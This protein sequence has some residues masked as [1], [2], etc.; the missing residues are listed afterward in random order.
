VL[1]RTLTAL[2]LVVSFANAPRAADWPMWRGDANRCAASP[3][4]LP[5]ELH[6]QW[7]RT[8][9][10]PQPAFP[11]DPRLCADASYEPVVLGKTLF[12]P[13]MVT[14]S[15]TAFDTETGAVKWRF[16]ADGPVRF[17]P[18]AWQDRI[19]FASDDGVLYCLDAAMG[20]VLWTFN[21]LPADRQAY[22]LLGNGRLVSRWPA[23]GG[24]VLADGVV[25]FGRG[26]WPNEGVFVYAVDAGTG[27][28]IWVNRDIGW[29]KDGLIDHGLRRHAGLSPLGYMV[30]MGEKLVVPSG[31]AFPAVLDRQTGKM[32]PYSTGWGGRDGLAKGDWRQSG[33]G[34]LLFQGGD[35]HALGEKAM[36][37]AGPFEPKEHYRFAEFAEFAGTTVDQVEAWVKTECLEEV[38]RDGAR[39][40]RVRNRPSITY[41]TW[42]MRNPTPGE[43]YS[44]RSC[45]RLQVDPGNRQ[46]QGISREAVLTAAAMYYSAP[47]RNIR[48]RG[49]LHP[50]DLGWDGIEAY[51]LTKAEWGVAPRSGWGTPR[52]FVLWPHLRFKRLWRLESDLKVH[53]KAGPRLY[54]GGPGAVAAVR[55]PTGAAQPAIAWRA[56]IEGTPHRMLAADDK[57]FVVTVE[58]GL[59]CFGGREAAPVTHALPSA[60]SSGGE[61]GDTAAR[62]LD[63]S[64]VR[65]GYC[66]A[67][68]I[69]T[70]RLVT[71]L[72]VRSQLHIIVVE[73]DAAKVAESRRSLA[74]KGLYGA[75][76]H[77]LPGDLRGLK[78][79]PYWA[80]LA[81]AEAPDALADPGT[82]AAAFA[83]LRPYGGV[84][85]LALTDEQHAAFAAAVDQGGLANAGVQRQGG[86]T[87]L[88]RVGAVPGADEWTHEAGAPGNTFSSN[89]VNV[90][91]PFGV[92]W[93]GGTVDAIFPSYDY[94][95][96]RGPFALI[97]R[98]RMFALAENVLHAADIYTGR[99]LWQVELPKT[100]KTKYRRRGHMVTQRE[101]ADNFI[102]TDDALYVISKRD[103]LL[104]DPATGAEKGRIRIPEE[105][106][107]HGGWSAVRI[108]REHLFASIGGH[109]CC[110]DRHSGA[111]VWKVKSSRGQFRFAVGPDRVFCADYQPR[112]GRRR[113]ENAE[114]DL[115]TTIRALAAATGRTLWDA[116][117]TV[118]EDTPK[119]KTQKRLPPLDPRLTY[120]ADSDV[121]VLTATRSILAGYRGKT[122]ERLWS[123]PIP[124][125]DPPNNFSGPEPPIALSDKLITHSGYVIDLST[126]EKLTRLWRGT[127][128]GTR[129]CNRVVAN[130]FII[131]L[132]DAH[133]SYFEVLTGRQT[134][135]RAVRSGCTNSQLA[136]GGILNAP[137]F[138]HGCACNWPLFMS[139]AMVHMPAARAWA[140]GGEGAAGE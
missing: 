113:G 70:G 11:E 134:F 51:D 16:H 108:R 34:E 69:G 127:N 20:K 80:G 87:L 79:S 46:E 125:H 98:G 36:A 55:I 99:R 28:P 90:K 94:T 65:E 63:L 45:P 52:R 43:E 26:F 126:G 56:E 82:V 62:I 74:A 93:F 92:L 76:V 54:A 138:A 25:Y 21:D 117:A 136:A 73:P 27:A 103:C 1:N 59:Y 18:V 129:G 68:G 114:G 24:P 6:L 100:V 13:S 77:V 110:L 91:P 67:V 19:C 89:D 4:A 131:P 40:I 3:A 10:A 78:L 23:R 30:V 102:A 37:L 81:V 41:I 115:T 33:I 53:I 139:Y 38:K 49:G 104:L 118:P 105:L 57:L 135:F 95:H 7:R 109:L 72:A 50:P 101:I 88:T 123:G 61:W 120:R 116:T 107:A 15:V 111:L 140:P 75:R 29:I 122:G 130:P 17:A 106:A 112:L 58:G 124:V 71:E 48:G 8:F 42:W 60:A 44:V 128:S 85:C 97:N 32:A 132:R 14:D 64:G 137:N 35:I 9:L 119:G 86:L 84:A 47:V 66:L 39:F 96:S 22:R 83:V 5:A 133:A 2:G 121:L 31:R 12:A